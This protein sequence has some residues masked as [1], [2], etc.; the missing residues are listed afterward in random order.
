MITM[1]LRTGAVAPRQRRLPLWW[2]VRQ[3]LVFP[4]F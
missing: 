4:M 3:V 2:R 1:F